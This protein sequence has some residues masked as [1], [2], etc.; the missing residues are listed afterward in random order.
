[1]D[2]NINLENTVRVLSINLIAILDVYDAR[3]GLRLSDQLLVYIYSP[4]GIKGDEKG[5]VV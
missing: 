5:M 3:M 2:V 1:M 4:M